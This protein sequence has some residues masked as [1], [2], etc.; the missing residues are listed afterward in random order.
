MKK[1]EKYL[2]PHI[3]VIEVENE[4]S[5]MSASINTGSSVSDF[6]S[7]GSLFPMTRNNAS[8]LSELEDMINDIL[9]FDK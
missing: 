3:E 6:N 8:A 7:G 2:T 4:G 9:T 5:V 1:K